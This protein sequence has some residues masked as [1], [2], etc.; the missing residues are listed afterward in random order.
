M[1]TKPEDNNIGAD[2]KDTLIK[3]QTTEL[4]NAGSR[5]SIAYAFIDLLRTAYDALL[6]HGVNYQNLPEYKA[7]SP[8]NDLGKYPIEEVKVRSIGWIGKVKHAI[9]A[10]V[11]RK[12]F[13]VH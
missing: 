7:D 2:P 12:N 13:K 5:L 9:E 4:R 1:D 3:K 6:H 11:R 10:Q 8:L